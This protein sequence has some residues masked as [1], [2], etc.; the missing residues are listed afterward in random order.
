MSARWYFS[1]ASLALGHF[2][3]ANHTL[4]ADPDVQINAPL[5][6][7]RATQEIAENARTLDRFACEFVIDRS[8]FIPDRSAPDARIIDAPR[9]FLQSEGGRRLAWSDR[10]HLQVALFGGRELFSWPEDRAFHSEPLDA[11]IAGGATGSGDFGPFAISIFL[12]DADPASFR[13]LGL[14]TADGRAVAEYSYRVREE[15]SHYSLRVDAGLESTG[16]DG[17]FWI[18]ANSADLRRLVVRVDHPPQGSHAVKAI[19]STDYK[20]SDVDGKPVILP[21]RSTLRILLD[22]GAV[23]VNRTQYGTCK[24][25]EAES[26]IRFDGDA[27]EQG[28]AP[29]DAAISSELGPLPSGL[30]LDTSLET[31]IDSTTTAAGDP[32]SARV[33]HDAK[34]GRS[35]VIQQGSVLRGRVVRLQRHYFPRRYTVTSLRFDTLEVNGASMPVTLVAL[36]PNP[37]DSYLTAIDAARM[38][39]AERAR[40][41]TE[42]TNQVTL[43]SFERKRVRIGPRTRFRWRVR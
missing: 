18:D 36:N 14:R 28:S 33:N 42:N 11:M 21:S 39:A 40:D 24:K 16:Y 10:I 4:G 29:D 7:K 19:V 1:F 31:P 9:D 37:D 23:A 13:F 2:I 41:E 30:E 25:Y 15:T 8:M 35:I 43:V 26:S 32:V 22:T 3:C 5:L 12:F 34:A 20:R 27:L 17:V 6:L 38:R